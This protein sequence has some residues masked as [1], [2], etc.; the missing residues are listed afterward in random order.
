M[1]VFRPSDDTDLPLAFAVHLDEPAVAAQVEDVA[2]GQLAGMAKLHAVVMPED[3]VL[4]GRHLVEFA[5][6]WMGKTPRDRGLDRC[7]KRGRG[8]RD[9]AKQDRL[10]VETELAPRND[11]DRLVQRAKAT[12]QRDEGV[13]KLEHPPLAAVH[14]IGHDQLAHTVMRH[15]AAGQEVR[16]HPGHA[17]SGRE[18]CVGHGAH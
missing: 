5:D 1:R 6:A 14:T 10:V 2:V 13:G 7:Q 4:I 16:N 12:G 15:L 8:A 9:V 18:R 3:L 17:A 11:L